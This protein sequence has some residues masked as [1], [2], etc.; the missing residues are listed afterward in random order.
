M[1]NLRLNANKS[2][3][4]T[5]I[6]I[7]I[8][9]AVIAVLALGVV[10][11]AGGLFSGAKAKNEA[12]AMQTMIQGVKKLYSTTATFGSLTTQVVLD[13]GL[14]PNSMNADPAILNAWGGN[15]TF[16]PQGGSPQFM[17]LSTTAVPSAE[18]VD[19]INELSEMSVTIGTAASTTNAKANGAAIIDPAVT[20]GLCNAAAAVDLNFVVN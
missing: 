4:F 6:E 20:T 11:A 5:I 10:A 1:K 14:V 7:V 9:L 17:V 19:L 2:K 16:T 8:V 12:Q 13:K 3:G 18:C 15:I